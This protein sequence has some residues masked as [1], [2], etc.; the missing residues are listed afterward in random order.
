MGKPANRILPALKHGIDSGLGLL[1][2]ESR[3]KFR[4]F[5]KQRFTE[6]A[7]TV[8]RSRISVWKSLLW[9]AP[10]QRWYAQLAVR[11]YVHV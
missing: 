5:K 9:S 8:H 4:R 11:R 7:L 2:T 1:P 3:A 10:Q 6:L